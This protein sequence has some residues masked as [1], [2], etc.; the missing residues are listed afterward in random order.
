MQ[1]AANNTLSSAVRLKLLVAAIASLYFF[2]C[3]YDPYQWHLIDGVNLVIHEAGHLIFSPF[4]EFM[5]IAGGSLFQVIMPALFV[6]YFLYQRQLYSAALVLFWVGESVLNVSVYAGDAVALQ[7]PLLGGEGSM[8]DWN[9]LLSS[10][11]LLDSTIQVAGAIR[12][13]GTII[14]ALAAFG[15][16]IFA[17]RETRSG[18]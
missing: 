3:A 14:I 8:H 11:N 15:S 2:W 9:Y 1:S 5:M 12:L 16:F 13:L 17:K 10:L 7:L 4:G 6:G 18:Q